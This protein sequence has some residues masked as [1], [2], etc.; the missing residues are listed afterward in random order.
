MLLLDNKNKKGIS[1]IIGYV[2]LIAFAVAIGTIVYTQLKKTIPTTELECPEG[3]LLFVESYSCIGEV[4]NITLKNNG[5]FS[6]GGYFIRASN[7][8]EYKIPQIELSEAIISDTNGDW[9]KPGIKIIELDPGL[10]NQLTPGDSVTNSF[11][12]S[13]VGLEETYSVEIVPIVWQIE[14]NLQKLLTCGKT[15]I[16]ENIQCQN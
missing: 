4:L 1:I 12:L 16:R 14:D 10:I 3:T 5:R 6:I 7:D 2:L 15:K 9:L 13:V 11:N 8:S